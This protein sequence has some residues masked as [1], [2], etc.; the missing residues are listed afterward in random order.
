MAMHRFGE[1]GMWLEGGTEKQIVKA[2]DNMKDEEMYNFREW[3]WL[4]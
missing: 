3:L 4:K 2:I 1:M